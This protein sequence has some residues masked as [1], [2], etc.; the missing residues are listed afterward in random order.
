MLAPK[1]VDIAVEQLKELDVIEL[2]QILGDQSSSFVLYFTF[3]E[4]ET[5]RVLVVCLHHSFD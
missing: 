3:P 4:P 1:V 5:R 2:D